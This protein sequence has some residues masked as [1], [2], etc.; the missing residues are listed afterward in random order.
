VPAG[1]LHAFDGEP[2]D[3]AAKLEKLFSMEK[4][5][6]AG[7]LNAIEHGH[8]AI[9]AKVFDLSK[10]AVILTGAT[11]NIGPTVLRAYLEQGAHVAIPVRDELKG[12]ELR[13]S[14]GDL[15]AAP[16]GPRLIVRVA[17]PGDRAAMEGVVEQV[18]RAWGRLDAVAN[19]IGGY[20]TSDAASGDLAAY[21]AY[22]DQKVATIVTATTACLRPMRARGYGRVVN[23]LSMAALKGEKG[24]AGY[25]MANAAVLR[26][27]ESLAEETKREGITA[28]CV[29]PRIIDTPANRAAMPK[30]DPTRWATAA[31]IAAAV[32]FLSTEE[33]SGITGAALPVVART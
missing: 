33:S 31:E 3:L 6:V 7:L 2:P 12:E 5:K 9:L 32:V 15:A 14:L 26:W 25:A 20:V 13:A 17:D 24:A 10:R 29:L 11:G 1:L 21:Q 8:I 30:A 22:W 27:T 23:V 18:L 28:N 4:P 19:L 16:E